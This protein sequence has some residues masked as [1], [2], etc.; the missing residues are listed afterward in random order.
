MSG[1]TESMCTQRQV[2]VNVV[3]VED[4]VSG[5]TG[6]LFFFFII[7]LYCLFKYLLKAHHP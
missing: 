4:S 7:N 2:L 5:E 6:V 1:G 3:L